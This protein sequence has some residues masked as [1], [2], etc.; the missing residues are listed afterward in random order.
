MDFCLVGRY[1]KGP[2]ISSIS[3][4]PRSDVGM[5]APRS[6]LIGYVSNAYHVSMLK[7]LVFAGKPAIDDP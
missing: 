1:P 2:K 5:H 4:D 7:Q 3:I 6:Q